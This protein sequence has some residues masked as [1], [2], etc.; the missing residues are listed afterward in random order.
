[1]QVVYWDQ[2]QG[3]EGV[4]EAEWSRGRSRTGAPSQY[5]SM[6]ISGPQLPAALT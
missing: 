4:R 1:M 5:R 6:G 2:H 3:G